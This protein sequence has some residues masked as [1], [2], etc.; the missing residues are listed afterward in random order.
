MFGV[1]TELA[2][3]EG[4]K[5]KAKSARAGLKPRANAAHRLHPGRAGQGIHHER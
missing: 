1:L 4:V 2:K 3:A 5:I